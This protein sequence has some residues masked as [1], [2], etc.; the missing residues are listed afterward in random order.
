MH[1][2]H[3]MITTVTLVL[4]HSSN[5]VS[6]V[7]VYVGVSI[8]TNWIYSLSKLQHITECQK[9]V[10]HMMCIR[11]PHLCILRR[12]NFSQKSLNLQH[13]LYQLNFIPPFTSMCS[14]W[15]QS[16][17]EITVSRTSCSVCLSKSG[18]F[19]LLRPPGSP[20]I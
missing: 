5:L 9:S 18:L 4:V 19:H 14:T 2:P 17:C 13:F 1:T 16:V 12:Y 15:L 20:V 11:S 8:E 6:F 7:C 3:K 10:V